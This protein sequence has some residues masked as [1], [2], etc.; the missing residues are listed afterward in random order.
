M[1]MMVNRSRPT[2][3]RRLF[4][5]S[6]LS[7]PRSSDELISNSYFF[8]SSFSFFPFLFLRTDQTSS[9]KKRKNRSPNRWCPRMRRILPIGLF[10]LAA[11][12]R[13][14]LVENSAREKKRRVN[15][16]LTNWSNSVWT[17]R[18]KETLIEND[19]PRDFTSSITYW[20]FIYLLFSL[21]TGWLDSF[22]RR[23]SRSRSKER[24]REFRL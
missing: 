15:H 2:D 17:S 16:R 23:R 7:L 1:M 14:W 5:F 4:L 13:A 19:G 3:E 24:K 11:C 8:F 9:R 22:Q 18:E 10:E 21:Q 12:L 20:W 6:S